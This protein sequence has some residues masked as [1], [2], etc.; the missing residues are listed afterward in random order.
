MWREQ[1]WRECVPTYS[2]IVTHD[3]VEFIGGRLMHTHVLCFQMPD[4]AEPKCSIQLQVTYLIFAYM[5]KAVLSALQA[6]RSR[7]NINIG[8]YCRNGNYDCDYAL[9]KKKYSRINMANI[10]KIHQ[11]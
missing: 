3:V 2:R 11:I 1:V 10:A 4:T 8:I 7:Y 6:L 5:L 9:R